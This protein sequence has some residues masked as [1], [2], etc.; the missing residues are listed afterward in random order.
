MYKNY[1]RSI[2]FCFALFVPLNCMAKEK[3]L[4]SIVKTSD[5]EAYSQA[6]AGLKKTLSES[7]AVAV[8]YSEH[9]LNENEEELIGKIRAEKPDLILTIGTAASKIV[10]NKVNDIPIVFCMVLDPALIRTKEKKNVCGCSIQ[11]PP[12]EA[13]CR[14]ANE[15]VPGSK[16]YGI[17]YTDKTK[18]FF[19]DM[20]SFA[21]K[22]NLQVIGKKISSSK[23]LVEAFND[24]SWR[25]DLL[26]MV[27]DPA[28]YT[29]PSTK[30]VIINCLAKKIAL[31]GL[32]SLYTEAGALLS[33]D[34][35]FEDIGRQA[36][37]TAL[38]VMKG[39]KPANIPTTTP[40]KYK[41]SINLLTAKKIGIEIQPNVY[42][43]KNI[44]V[45]GQ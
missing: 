24:L 2:L 12:V 19:N 8:A 16:R 33:F 21:K 11:I 36:G 43:K 9:G 14:F 31:V 34:C 15:I 13:Q 30:Y 6:E 41:P 42:Q 38:K 26:F 22:P 4:I 27:P 39:E 3:A 35:D 25:I 28:I 45:F 44:E 17:I 37:E 40:E 29:M 1:A 20:E 7:K 18:E 23:E 10:S 32:S 5:S